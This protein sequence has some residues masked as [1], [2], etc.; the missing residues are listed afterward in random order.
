MSAA[1]PLLGVAESLVDALRQIAEAVG[2]GDA[3][4][5][6]DAVVDRVRAVVAER[7]RLHA[8]LTFGRLQTE[9]LPWAEHNGFSPCPAY[10]PLL[11][12]MEELGE[13]AHAQLKM[14]Q[15][16]RGPQ[17]KHI[18]EAKDAV[19]DIGIFLVAYCAAMDFD[20]Q[21]LMEETWAMV[22]QRDF[23]ANSE[24]GGAARG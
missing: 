10:R 14:E 4:E 11:G 1:N 19:A 21:Q 8:I 12:A 3:E 6:D 5:L 23:K 18:A 7:D 20:F 2:I 15:G 16:I 13:L 9:Y 22:R 17:E 24:T